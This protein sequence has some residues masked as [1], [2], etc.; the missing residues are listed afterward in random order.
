MSSRLL[1][2][3]EPAEAST[4]FTVKEMSLIVTVCPTGFRAP[5]S[6]CAV[7][8]PST[9]TVRALSSSAAVMNVPE[10]TL[11]ART[12][13]HCGVLPTTDVVQLV[14]PL[15]ISSEVLCVGA[16]A[17]TSGAAVLDFSAFAS[18]IVKV[19]ADPKPPR[20]PLELVE[21]PGETMSRLL[22]NALIWSLTDVFVPSPSPTDSTTVAMPIR[23]PR[24]VSPERNRCARTACR[25]VRRVSDQFTRRLRTR[26]GSGRRAL[27][28]SGRRA[29][30]RLPRA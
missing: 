19:A 8:G 28:R 20:T 21:L 22:P 30:R 18:L 16:T 2:E 7:L 5:N 1:D 10:D 27:A 13:D 23:M 24:T 26:A 11:R 25:P 4:P 3:S 14:L 17:A 15:S 29:P 12:C 9:T 6:S